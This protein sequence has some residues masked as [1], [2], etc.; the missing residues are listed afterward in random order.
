MVTEKKDKAKGMGV[1]R[2]AAAR[3]AAGEVYDIGGMVICRGQHRQP[4]SGR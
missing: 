4:D 3:M 2:P 1:D